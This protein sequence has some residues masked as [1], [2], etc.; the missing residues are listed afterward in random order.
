MRVLH[1]FGKAFEQKLVKL[2]NLALDAVKVLGNRWLIG[3]RDVE[4]ERGHTGTGA[5]SLG[6]EGF[7]L[8]PGEDRLFF[9]KNQALTK[10]VP[11][12]FQLVD[13]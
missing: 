9:V 7:E 11:F 6:G 8:Q 13:P 12:G 1:A 3:A 5:V 10:C 2:I 4:F